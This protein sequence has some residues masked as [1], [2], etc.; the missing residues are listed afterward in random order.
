MR[1]IGPGLFESNTPSMVE[2]RDTIN[3]DR[4]MSQSWHW[5]ALRLGIESGAKV[6]RPT[7]DFC[8]MNQ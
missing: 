2:T 4:L 7:Q 8:P 3:R 1:T 5:V 6:P